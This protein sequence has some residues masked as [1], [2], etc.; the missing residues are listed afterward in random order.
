[1]ASPLPGFMQ[2]W[3]DFTDTKSKKHDQNKH[4]LYNNSKHK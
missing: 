3:F 4:K 1:M 2:Q